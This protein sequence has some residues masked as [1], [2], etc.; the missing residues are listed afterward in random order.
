ML[1]P[2]LKEGPEAYAIGQKIRTHRSTGLQHRGT[3]GPRHCSGS[4]CR[5][6]R[7][8]IDPRRTTRRQ[9]AGRH[10]GRGEQRGR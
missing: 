1:S 8:R 4:F 6:H 7:D 5:Q 2:T 3:A 9:I 10:G